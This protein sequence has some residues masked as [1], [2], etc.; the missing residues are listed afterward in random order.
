[1]DAA[2]ATRD[3]SRNSKM[4]PGDSSTDVAA[5]PVRTAR[6]GTLHMENGHFY[7]RAPAA[8]EGDGA[9]PDLEDEGI[10]S[11]ECLM[12]TSSGTEGA[13]LSRVRFSIHLPRP[14]PSVGA[15]HV[16]TRKSL[17]SRATEEQ[18]RVRYTPDSRR[19]E[20]L[21]LDARQQVLR[22]AAGPT[23][24]SQAPSGT[25]FRA[26]HVLVCITLYNEP[27]A[28]LAQT[29]AC[30]MRSLAHARAAGSRR[31][32]DAA[33][34]ILIDGPER[35][36][37]EMIPFLQRAG[38]LPRDHA[39]PGGVTRFFQSRRSGHDIAWP[40]GTRAVEDDEPI[41][42]VVCL[43]D[44]NHGKLHSH[45]LFFGH[46]AARLDPRYCFQLDTGTNVDEGAMHA[47]LCGF[48]D[49]P[50]CG[51][52][53]SSVGT[54]P[55]A[56][57]DGLVMNWQHMDFEMQHSVDWLAETA[58]GHLSVLPG[59]F[60][61]FRW[62]ALTAG[63][64]REAFWTEEEIHGALL[65]PRQDPLSRYLR[66]IEEVNPVQRMMYLAE[67]R[68]IGNE[69]VLGDAHWH[70]GYAPGAQAFTDPCPALPE[71]LR[72]RRRWNNSSSAC[73]L[74]MLARWPAYMR[75]ADRSAAHKARFSC[76]M[77]W[78]ALFAAKQFLMPA[79]LASMAILLATGI[80]LTLQRSGS[81]PLV[82]LGVLVLL[83][84]VLLQPAALPRGA[85]RIGRLR[86]AW[87]VGTFATVAYIIAHALE[88]AALLLV[89]GPVLLAT[90]M[91]A[92]DSRSRPRE[93]WS[94][95][96]EYAVMDVPMQVLLWSYSVRH[97]GDLSWGTK[98][99]TD[100]PAAGQ[101]WRRKTRLVGLAWIAVN[102]AA[103]AWALLEPSWVF[104]NLNPVATLL[105][106]SA[107][108]GVTAALVQ[109]LRGHIGRTRAAAA[110][111]SAPLTPPAAKGR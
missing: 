54:A 52:L 9:P 111:L 65:D 49:Q 13:G 51:A 67:D 75:R 56:I 106:A 26:D 92:L 84:P 95:A 76:A 63:Q 73:R 28:A 61:G 81:A 42:V 12:E 8:V 43:K 5:T 34:A 74:W 53:A 36:H 55:P 39:T 35:A 6:G 88:P 30:M 32:G 14:E 1:M 47:M 24:A 41:G 101:A 87:A 25:A 15:S 40:E 18:V 70:L 17:P 105:S 4:M 99:L 21:T 78:Q 98:G 104:T 69:L 37:P 44:R 90:A 86:G 62:E 72:Q 64:R 100:G 82:V 38:L 22:H 108:T 23:A 103:I 58:T 91:V 33:V 96:A 77:V 79:A 83:A 19:F 46:L 59:Q 68:I 11:F 66:G 45:A 94:R 16:F 48:Q 31:A 93:V 71:L 27:P 57:T 110:V 20:V 107:A 3:V 2:T 89:F 97:M 7:Y 29:L 80:T 50:R 60:C 85:A 10:D 102:A 109:R